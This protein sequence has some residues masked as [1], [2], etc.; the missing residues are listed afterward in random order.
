VGL[1]QLRQANEPI[2]E[3]A[4]VQ[5]QKERHACSPSLSSVHNKHSQRTF[6]SD[7]LRRQRLLALNAARFIL[8][9]A[10][11]AIRRFGYPTLLWGGEPFCIPLAR[12]GKLYDLRT[13]WHRTR[14]PAWIARRAASE[15]RAPTR[16]SPG[17][18]VTLQRCPLINDAAVGH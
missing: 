4:W 13:P 3:V 17:T 7:P 9:S 18:A 12:H 5:G 11:H 16:C 1:N 10:P 8:V 6:G 15:R 14:H 2:G